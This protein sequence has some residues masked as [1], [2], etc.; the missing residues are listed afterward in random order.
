MNSSVIIPLFS[1]GN[2]GPPVYYSQP[3]KKALICFV[4]QHVFRRYNTWMYP[5]DLEGIIQTPSG[6]YMYADSNGAVYY[7][8]GETKWS[9]RNLRLPLN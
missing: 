7:A 6:N 4:M 5:D 2:F 9:E 3:P 1:D 8:K